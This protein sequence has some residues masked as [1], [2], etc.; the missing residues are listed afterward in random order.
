MAKHFKIG[1]STAKRTLHCPAW[2]NEAAKLPP[3]NRTSAAAE[4]GT[5]MHS[6]MEL[7]LT[8]LEDFEDAFH[9]VDFPFDDFDKAQLRAAY[10]A[11][12]T[13]WTEYEIDEYE[14]EPLMTVAEDVGGSADIVAAGEKWVL[15]ADFKFGRV[16][17]DPVN[18]L[19]ILFYHWLA[20][21]DPK[22]RDLVEGRK[23]VG[24]IIQP[25][26]SSE[27]LVYEYS[28]EEVAIFDIDIRDAIEL[29]RSG[30]T[31]PTPGDHCE[32]CPVEPY[33]SAR[34]EA[35]SD[36]RLMPLDQ[37]NS[38]AES[39]KLIGQLEAFIKATEAEAERVMKDLGVKVPG[40]KLVAKKELRKFADPFK[41]AAALTSA[42]L[43]DIYSPP[44]LKSPAQIEKTLKEEKVSFDLS[45]W[46]KAPSGETEI[47]PETDKREEIMLNPK[48][49][50]DILRN[51]SASNS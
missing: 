5:A 4:R 10:A 28:E 49:I 23:L 39:M 33:C 29:V 20:M 43:K 8:S 13:L 24:A 14:I 17:V 25:A 26:V 15:V 38:L 1:G 11:V 22:L 51:N 2:V 45:P 48:T 34:R 12:S 44:S 50:S 6:V 3:V 27:P 46:L 32:Y 7:L 30:H 42:G 47:A 37:V 35:I 41:T 16:P 40:F 21:Q 19:Q 9:E 31:I 18:N 36:I